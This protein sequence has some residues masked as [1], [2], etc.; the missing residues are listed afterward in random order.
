MN[1]TRRPALSDAQKHLLDSVQVPLLQP[2][3][4]TRFHPWLIEQHY[5]HSAHLVGEPARYVAESQ[6]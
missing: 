2:G 5:L 3:A 4:R 1:A 6:G